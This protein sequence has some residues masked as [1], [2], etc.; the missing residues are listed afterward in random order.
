M[1]GNGAKTRF[2]NKFSGNTANTVSTVLDAHKRFFKMIYVVDLSAGHLSKLFS[3]HAHAAIF[4]RHVP[5]LVL[6]SAHF[7]L[8]RD[9]SL[10]VCKFFLGLVKFLLY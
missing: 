8:S 1:V 10:Q 7:I 3:F 5:V 6:I 2:I 4:H 9:Q